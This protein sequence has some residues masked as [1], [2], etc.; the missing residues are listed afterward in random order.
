MP[1][2]ASQ[3]AKLNQL[4]PEEIVYNR[5]KKILL[6]SLPKESDHLLDGLLYYRV[7]VG[8]VHHVNLS[9]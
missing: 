7:S 1:S 6:S 3:R 8:M 5:Q 9:L 4:S 2:S